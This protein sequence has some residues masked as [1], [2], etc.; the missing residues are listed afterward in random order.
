MPL[1][2][3]AAEGSPTFPAFLLPSFGIVKLNLLITISTRRIKSDSII[4]SDVISRF[5]FFLILTF[6]NSLSFT[7]S[8]LPFSVIYLIYLSFER[9]LY[10]SE[11]C[12]VAMAFC[13]A[14]ISSP[15]LRLTFML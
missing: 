4:S 6:S 3:A 1:P 2:A 5:P 8:I 14:T 13:E 7:V 15:F 10:S 11:K 9:C 12:T